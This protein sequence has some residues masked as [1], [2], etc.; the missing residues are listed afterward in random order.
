[1]QD[2]VKQVIVV[3]TRFP[4]VAKGPTETKSVRTGKMIAQGAH[5]S[6]AV[7][8]NRMGPDYALGPAPDWDWENDVLPW[9][10][11]SFAKIVLQVQTGEELQ[12]IYAQGVA[13]GIPCAIIQDSGKTE[14][15]GVPTYTTLALGPA[16]AS[17]IDPITQNLKLF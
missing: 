4:D 2:P 7:F 5:A 11:G 1:M 13:A 3:R 8:L 14:F 16:R 6:L 17:K 10:Q 15:Q 9:L 12:D